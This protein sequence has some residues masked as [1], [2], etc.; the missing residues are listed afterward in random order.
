MHCRANF[1]AR[2]QQSDLDVA[3]DAGTGD[4]DYL[5]TLRTTLPALIDRVRPD[6]AFYNA[7]VDPHEQ[8]RLG[9][10]ALTDAGLAEREAFVLEACRSRGVPLAC[11]ARRWLCGAAGRPRG[12]AC[13]PAPGR[14]GTLPNGSPDR[15][16]ILPGLRMSRGS[17]ARLIARI[18]VDRL[19]DL[20]GDAVDLAEADAVLAGAGAAH[21]NG[22]AHHALV[23]LLGPRASRSG[24]RG[25]E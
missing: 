15:R 17:S 19:A 11:V 2:K 14:R 16:T 25:R 1:P 23:D 8:D 6:L 13:H 20:L 22:P 7:G 21:G 5:A 24:H 12:T 9:R 4:A 3:L 10:L 18:I